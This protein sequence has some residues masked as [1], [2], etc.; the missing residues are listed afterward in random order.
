MAGKKICDIVVYVMK[1]NRPNLSDIDAFVFDLDGTLLNGEHEVSQKTADALKG[2]QKWGKKLI[3]CTGRT[4][5]SA[6]CLIGQFHSTMP[7]V[8]GNGAMVYDPISGAY[9]HKILLGKDV[10]DRLYELVK[11]TD[12]HLQ[13]FTPEIT[14]IPQEDRKKY[15]GIAASVYVSPVEAGLPVAPQIVKAM[16]YG[17]KEEEQ[18]PAIIEELKKSFPNRLYA[19]TTFSQHVEIMDDHVNKIHGLRSVS[20]LISIPLSR[21][22]AFGDADS[23]IEM[24]KGVGWSVV[25]GNGSDQA[26]ATA[27]DMAGDNDHDGIAEYLEDYLKD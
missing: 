21:M 15:T 17:E 5:A 26:K 25:M 16:I 13:L 8:L 10:V 24:L 27:D 6:V 9:S 1:K 18:G 19:V 11:P 7:L 3:F 14:Y 2:L 22:M 23:D 12:V 20:D 4:Y